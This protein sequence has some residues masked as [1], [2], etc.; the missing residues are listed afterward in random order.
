MRLQSSH[1]NDDNPIKQ[2]IVEKI[3]FAKKLIFSKFSL[4]KTIIREKDRTKYFIM[5]KRCQREDTGRIGEIYLFIFVFVILFIYFIRV[6]NAFNAPKPKNEHCNALL[7]PPGH[8]EEFA[9]TEIV[10]LGVSGTYSNVIEAVNPNNANWYH[11]QCWE[12]NE[13]LK[14]LET[15]PKCD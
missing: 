1:I 2:Q 10:H 9:N 5:K 8:D 6:G 13:K 3:N 15:N 14:Y 7:S 4:Y 11:R 12:K